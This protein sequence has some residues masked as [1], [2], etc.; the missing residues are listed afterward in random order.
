MAECKSS[1]DSAALKLCFLNIKCVSLAVIVSSIS[2]GMP[3]LDRQVE[4]CSCSINSFCWKHTRT[5]Y[6]CAF[7][8]LCTTH[9]LFWSFND[10]TV[11]SNQSRSYFPS[12]PL[13]LILLDYKD[14]ICSLGGIWREN[15]QSFKQSEG[16]KLHLTSQN[17]PWFY[18]DTIFISYILLLNSFYFLLELI[19]C[20]CIKLHFVWAINGNDIHI[21]CW[22]EK[23]LELGTRFLFLPHTQTLGKKSMHDNT[24]KINNNK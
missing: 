23:F 24:I 8:C 9:F 15:M 18:T 11:L 20:L 5:Q 7:M 22:Q 3:G 6:L 16:M 13:M 12:V 10:F 17:P 19:V 2:C 14:E 1:A 21:S 4:M